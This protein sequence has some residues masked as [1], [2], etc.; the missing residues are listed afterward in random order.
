MGFNLLW[1][2]Y[3]KKYIIYI[4]ASVQFVLIVQV[5]LNANL[6]LSGLDTFD[7]LPHVYRPALNQSYNK[8]KRRP[9]V[10]RKETLTEET[11]CDDQFV[12][13]SSEFAYLTNVTID[14]SSF[15]SRVK[16][17]EDMFNVINQSEK[18]EYFTF[19]RGA[20]TQ[21]CTNKTELP[22]FIGVNHLNQWKLG[23]SSMS[24]ELDSDYALNSRFTIA[25]QRYEYAN[26]YHTMTDWY[27]AFLMKELFHHIQ[28]E[29]AIL[30]V[31]TH[32]K[33]CLDSTWSVLFHSVKRLTSLPPRSLFINMVW[34]IMGYNSPLSMF[35]ASQLP[36]VE[37]FRDYFFNR[38]R[39]PDNH[40]LSCDHVNITLIWRHDYVTHPRNPSGK[41][42]R[43]IQNEAEL[44][45]GIQQKYPSHT[46][47][48][49]QIDLLT[50][51][52]QLSHIGSTDIL[53]GMHGAGL[54]HALF[55][56]K[57]AAIIELFPFTMAHRHF[58]SIAMWRKLIY[59]SWTDEPME[60]L[61][62]GGRSTKVPPDDIVAL[63]DLVIKEMCKT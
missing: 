58:I 43:K 33:G 15:K 13:Y 12:V 19:E 36:L 16:G 5:L 26:L 11:F 46:V 14:T 6:L 63:L 42:S 47:T 3:T 10:Y 1:K 40:K 49:V 44:L 24:K 8:S 50:M 52:D 18:D 27:N 62:D 37:E 55:L 53:I 23:H 34:N 29:P 22:D 20:F 2:K 48:G 57:H 35:D 61:M 28:P 60:H 9:L 54:T 59:Y 41:I 30:F 21:V 7:D 45:Q 31:D 17:G 25:I 32:P 38:F 39:L 51:S 4:L 56:P